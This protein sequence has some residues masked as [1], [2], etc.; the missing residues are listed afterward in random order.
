MSK[1]RR[2]FRH[3]KIFS[4]LFRHFIA[5]AMQIHEKIKQERDKAGLNPSQMAAR[6]GIPRT[7][8]LYW[9]TKTP[10]I[11]KIKAVAKALGK[12]E[13]FFFDKTDEEKRKSDEKEY[14]TVEDVG[15]QMNDDGVPYE[16]YIPSH[17][18]SAL[19]EEKDRAIRKAEQHYEDAK[20]DKE[21]LFMALNKLQE[22]FDTTLKEI[23]NNL[24][25]AALSLAHSK[26]DLDL[27]KDQTYIV[28]TQLEHQRDALG[29][30]L[31]GE[32][33]HQPAPFVKK[34]KA[35]AGHQEDGGKKSKGH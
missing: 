3:F 25:N 32:K 27:L 12:D 10:D 18:I 17:Y 9:E 33:K 23:S 8:Y 30:G 21:R 16:R 7:T 29:L 19:L 4:S 28:S 34:G 6:L 2:N 5:T 31:P 24:K 35:A 26:Q 14:K 22:T 13:N 11:D 15:S 1:I 20:E